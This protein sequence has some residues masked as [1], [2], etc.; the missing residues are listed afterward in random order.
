MW[1]LLM[2]MMMMLLMM[3]LTEGRSKLSKVAHKIAPHNRF[4]VEPKKPTEIPNGY[5]D[6]SH[7]RTSS[8]ITTNNKHA[9]KQQP[10]QASKREKKY[11]I[12]NGRQ[13]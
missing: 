10:P 5:T 12:N 2:M 4:V 11:K 1:L 6:N 8:H 3:R 9:R 7:T 13:R